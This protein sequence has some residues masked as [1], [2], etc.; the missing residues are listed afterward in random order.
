MTKS[1]WT[2]SFIAALGLAALAATALQNGA[3]AESMSQK[4]KDKYRDDPTVIVGNVDALDY[5]RTLF[6][7]FGQKT[8]RLEAPLGMCFLDETNYTERQI[9][10][11][12]REFLDEKTQ[13]ELVAAFVD[14]LQMSAVGQGS[15]DV[16]VTDGGV[17]T[18]PVVPGEKV[19][20]TLQEYLAQR[21]YTD[22]ENVRSMLIDFIDLQVDE[23][24]HQTEGG[25]SRGY[26][27]TFE[28]SHEKIQTVGVAGITM[29]QGLPVAINISHSGKKLTRTKDEL[30]GIMEKMLLQ[31]VALNNV[32]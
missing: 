16:R 2:K 4:V 28:S 25:V 13:H 10:N 31:Q 5:R 11:S 17:I 8:V 21:D 1:I 14:C 29:V 30:Y 19:P 24:P 32:R 22:E 26:T 9:M 27:G 15:Q 3:F 7:P 20:S 23:T 6:A 18:W 12:L